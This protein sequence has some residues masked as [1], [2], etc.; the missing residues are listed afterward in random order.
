MPQ[1]TAKALRAQYKPRRGNGKCLV[2]L[3]P[4]R[5]AEPVILKREHTAAS[6]YCAGSGMCR[7]TI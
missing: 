2:T 6:T 1:L 5:S 7:M 3:A 4:S